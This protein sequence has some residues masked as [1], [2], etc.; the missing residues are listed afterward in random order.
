MA[1]IGGAALAG[2]Y[3]CRSLESDPADLFDRYYDEPLSCD[4]SAVP[5]YQHTSVAHVETVAST[6]FLWP[7]R[8]ARAFGGYLR[9]I[10]VQGNAKA[11]ESAVP[12]FVHHS[13]SRYDCDDTIHSDS[14][15]GHEPDL[16]VA[17][18][19]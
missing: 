8:H 6:L 19:R 13:R 7:C 10:L 16:V 1:I 15:V 5:G 18:S 3:P 11:T 9:S 17:R 2:E 14:D 4:Y 12:G